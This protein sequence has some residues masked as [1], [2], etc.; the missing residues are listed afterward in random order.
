MDEIAKK[1]AVIKGDS[2]LWSPIDALED[3]I[4]YLKDKDAS[5]I[6][7]CIHWFEVQEDGSRDHHYAAANC[8]VPEH[9]ALIQV[10]QYKLIHDWVI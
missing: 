2:R 3:T 4:G 1:R 7:L 6:N 10:A 9:M 5:K 8:T